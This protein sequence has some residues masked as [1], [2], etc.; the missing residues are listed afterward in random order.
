MEDGFRKHVFTHTVGGAG[1][2]VESAMFSKDGASVLSVGVDGAKVWSVADGACKQHCGAEEFHPIVAGEGCM[3]FTKFSPDG[4]MVLT[5]LRG[6]EVKRSALKLWSVED[7]LCKRSF[8]I[9]EESEGLVS[10]VF[11]HR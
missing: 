11:S 9:G 10:A 1:T 3:P 8:D 2:P 4:T 5:G 6:L 7:G